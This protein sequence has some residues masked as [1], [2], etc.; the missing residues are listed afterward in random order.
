MKTSTALSLILLCAAIAIPGGGA[1]AGNCEATQWTWSN[2]LPQGNRVKDVWGANCSS[3]YAVAWPGTI[4]HYDGARWTVVPEV[5]PVNVGW[6]WGF[7]ENDIYAVGSDG[8]L[9]YDGNSWVASPKTV[10]GPIRGVW[11]M[12][13]T[14]YFAT[15]NYYFY[16]YDGSSWSQLSIPGPAT[17]VWGI[18]VDDVVFGAGVQGGDPD[19]ADG[20]FIRWNDGVISTHGFADPVTR[21]WASDPDNMFAY[22]GALHRFDGT[23]WT[24]VPNN[25]PVA[26][27]LGTP[28]TNLIVANGNGDIHSYDGSQ[29]NPLCQT[30]INISSAGGDVWVTPDGCAVA[31]GYGGRMAVCNGGGVETTEGMLGSF[32]DVWGSGP[33]DVFA[34]GE[35]IGHFDGGNWS[36]MADPVGYPAGQFAVW[37]FGPDA[38]YSVGA[39]GTVLRYDG[40]EWALHTQLD[41]D[42]LY[43]VWGTSASDLYVG[44]YKHDPLYPPF[45]NDNAVLYHFDGSMWSLLTDEFGGRCYGVVG[46]GG[47][48]YMTHGGVL[49]RRDATGWT[50]VGNLGSTIHAICGTGA[51]VVYA[52]SNDKLG[53]Y[54][55]V[56]WGETDLSTHISYN[57]EDIWAASD[58]DFWIVGIGGQILHYDDGTWS[59]PPQLTQRFLRGVWGSDACNVFAAGVIGTILSYHS[60]VPTP[61]LI[62]GLDARVVP[63]GVELAWTIIADEAIRSFRIQREHVGGGR[64]VV[65]DGGSLDDPTVRRFFDTTVGPGQE[66]RYT[67]TVVLPDGA[68]IESQTV[69]VITATPR[70][71]LYPTYPNPFHP[72]VHIRYS[73]PSSRTVSLSVYDPAGRHIVDIMRGQ[74]SPGIHDAEWNGLDRNGAKVASGVYFL[75]LRSGARSITR[76]ITLIR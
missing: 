49:R 45:S 21:V 15:G 43:C 35:Q 42:A 28:A 54:D 69:T 59:A 46:E 41:A 11:G 30:G 5:P 12:S 64:I 65:F 37:G 9:H 38:V 60:D 6:I 7:S 17:G 25:P 14:L 4:L 31:V 32:Y 47:E 57:V 52:I 8:I 44:G 34:V 23:S 18:G 20:I 29:W 56:N 55:G 53:R 75:R 76:K 1:R 39:P 22:T 19:D 62:S 16:R 26:R 36:L 63:G 73:L 33:K 40:V 71:E 58:S 70:L 61:V 48:L 2:P 3:I 66:Y 74:Q 68:E 51:G 13:D 67:L 27:M 10:P 50:S 24:V 72:L